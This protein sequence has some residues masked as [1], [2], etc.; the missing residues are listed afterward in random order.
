MSASEPRI[1]Q[2]LLD[3]LDDPAFPE[4][5]LAL[6]AGRHVGPE[7]LEEHALLNRAA[8]LVSSYYERYGC[9]LASTSESVYFL[10]DEQGRLP[11][12]TLTTA[13]MLVGQALA[14]LSLTPEVMAEGGVI[15]EGRLMEV[16]EELITP[17]ERLVRLLVSGRRAGR[18]TAVDSQRAREAVATAVTRLTRLGFVDRVDHTLIPR[19]AILRFTDP[20]RHQDDPRVGLSALV[21]A[22]GV[23]VTAPGAETTP[24]EDE[25]DDG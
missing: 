24:D 4:L 3:V 14:L 16:L 6:R 25:D 7:D 17:D 9:R 15:P 10:V 21:A 1:Y 2:S 12:R 18:N 5:D 20:V 22:G 8:E 11:R 19:A 13:E 23:V